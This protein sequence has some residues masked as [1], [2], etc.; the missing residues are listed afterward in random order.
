MRD[1]SITLHQNGS[2]GKAGQPVP[3]NDMAI[4]AALRESLP[5]AVHSGH[6][7]SITIFN[8][9]IIILS[10]ASSSSSFIH[11]AFIIRNTSVVIIFEVLVSRASC[12]EEVT[13]VIITIHHHLSSSSSSSSLSS[14]IMVLHL[15]L[16]KVEVLGEFL[17]L[18]PDHVLVL[19]ERLR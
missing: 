2:R 18:L 7:I 12:K 5:S 1:S 3:S 6:K 16:R 13:I 10:S 4:T 9:A 19:L 17:P 8:V 14:I 11:M 15:R